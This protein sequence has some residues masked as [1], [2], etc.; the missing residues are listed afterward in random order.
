VTFFEKYV[1]KGGPKKLLK[2]IGIILIALFVALLIKSWNLAKEANATT[3]VAASDGNEFDRQV[4]IITLKE[5]ER[6]I[7][8]NLPQ[9]LDDITILNRVV[10]D[11]TT[12]RYFYKVDGIY[13]K[14]EWSSLM[15]SELI[16]FVC[17][18]PGMKAIL[19][20]G[21]SYEFNYVDKNNDPLASIALPLSKCL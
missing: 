20:Q 3:T 18:A 16:S 17:G 14:A 12:L 11:Q 15:E 13:D 8:Q 2:R 4:L 10:A 21:G 6:Q 19:D 5:T 9:R 7:S 1:Y